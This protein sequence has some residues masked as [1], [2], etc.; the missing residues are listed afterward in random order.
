MIRVTRIRQQ[1]EKLIVMQSV[2][3]LRSK[4]KHSHQVRACINNLWK[5][6]VA[7]EL[8]TGMDTT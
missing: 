7:T 1:P 4:W 6:V 3:R 5:R 2:A 8:E